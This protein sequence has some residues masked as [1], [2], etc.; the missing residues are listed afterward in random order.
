MHTDETA[1][2]KNILRSAKKKEKKEKYSVMQDIT[3]LNDYKIFTTRSRVKYTT[4]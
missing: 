1:Y 2:L 3:F 4:G